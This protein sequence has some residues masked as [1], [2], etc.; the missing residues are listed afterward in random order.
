M[1]DEAKGKGTNGLRG[2]SERQ[3]SVTGR[4]HTAGQHE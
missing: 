2:E 1:E 4:S 3:E